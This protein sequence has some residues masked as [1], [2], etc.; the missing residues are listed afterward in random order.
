MGESKKYHLLQ[1]K[2]KKQGIAR[3]PV[4][5]ATWMHYSLPSAWPLFQGFHGILSPSLYIHLSQVLVCGSAHQCT[6]FSKILRLLCLQTAWLVFT[7]VSM[8][9][10]SAV[11]KGS[12]PRDSTLPVLGP[13]LVNESRSEQYALEQT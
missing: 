8:A 2:P 3:Q 13:Y 6:E 5:R 4:L 7:T 12:R 1:N 9:L 11:R 10:G